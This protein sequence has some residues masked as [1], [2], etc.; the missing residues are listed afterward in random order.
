MPVGAGE[1]VRVLML[2]RSGR[3]WAIA[4]RQT[5]ENNGIATLPRS[6]GPVDQASDGDEQPPSRQEV[7]R[8]AADKFAAELGVKRRLFP[9]PAVLAGKE[10]ELMLSVQMAALVSVLAVRERLPD[11]RRNQLVQ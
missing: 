11:S 3:S 9:R 8:V 2:A 7:F 4:L 5:L 6:L 10:F 1:R